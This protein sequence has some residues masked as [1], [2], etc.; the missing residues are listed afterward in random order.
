[1][2]VLVFVLDVDL[3]LVLLFVLDVELVLV[4]IRMTRFG[5]GVTSTIVTSQLEPA[6]WRAVIGDEPI[7]DAISDRLV[8]PSSRPPGETLAGCSQRGDARR[9]LRQ[10]P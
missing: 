10:N 4:L 9:P 8:L 7:A 6:D 1:V 3:V 2:L 5:S